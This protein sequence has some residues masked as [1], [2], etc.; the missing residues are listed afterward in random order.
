LKLPTNRTAFRGAKTA[1]NQ[2][3]SNCARRGNKPKTS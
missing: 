2:S 3:E 1:R